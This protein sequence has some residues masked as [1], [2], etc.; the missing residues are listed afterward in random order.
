M[1]FR[2]IAVGRIKAGPEQALF[3]HYAAR[4]R[5][6]IVLKEVEEKRPLSAA[7]LKA[8]QAEL[9]LAALAEGKGRRAVVVLDERGK[10]LTSREFATRLQR[11]EDDGAGEI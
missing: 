5:P 11:F 8:R 4:V 10:T 6:A 7:E 9:L 1:K 2:I 3:E